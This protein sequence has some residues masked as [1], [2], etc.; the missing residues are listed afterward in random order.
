MKKKGFT[1]IEMLV[2]VLIIA[3][4]ATIGIPWYQRA[5]IRAEGMEIVSLLKMATVSYQHY[6]L[7]NG[8]YP[9]RPSQLDVPLPGFTGNTCW[10]SYGHNSTNCSSNGKW[11]YQ[12]SNWGGSSAKRRGVM[13]GFLTGPYRGCGFYIPS[14]SDKPIK[15][16]YCL[17]ISTNSVTFTKDKG[18]CCMKI[19]HAKPVRNTSNVV[20]SNT[21]NHN[22]AIP[23][24]WYLMP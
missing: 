15:S 3:I 22:F 2:V 8:G 7:M 6:V 18:D 17:E 21:T 1:L 11:G 12:M 20:V 13:M 16:I 10:S 9:T 24:N 14:Y 4:L 5:I 19:F 23:F